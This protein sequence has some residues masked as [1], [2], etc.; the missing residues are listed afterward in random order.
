MSNNTTVNPWILDTTGKVT[1]DP[2]RVAALYFFPSA[3]SEDCIVKDR[4]NNTIWSVRSKAAAAGGGETYAVE[5]IQFNPPVSVGGFVV[6]AIGS[7]TVRVYR[8]SII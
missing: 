2:V 5:S 7:G 1:D 3:A 4:D 6:S 8:A